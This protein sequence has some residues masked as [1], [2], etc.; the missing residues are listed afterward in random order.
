MPEGFELDN[1]ILSGDPEEI[2][3]HSMGI[4]YIPRGNAEIEC[5]S[6]FVNWTIAKK[7]VGYKIDNADEDDLENAFD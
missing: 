7:G 6:M 4:K 2:M 3:M 5:R 1:V